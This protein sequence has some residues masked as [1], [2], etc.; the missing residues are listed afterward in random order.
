[1]SRKSTGEYM[2]TVKFTDGAL[3]FDADKF[4]VLAEFEWA[5]IRGRKQ[6]GLAVARARGSKGGRP[7]GSIHVYNV[8]KKLL[9]APDQTAMQIS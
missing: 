5:I 8:S 9:T 1:M 6:A 3:I 4:A 7:I 2:S